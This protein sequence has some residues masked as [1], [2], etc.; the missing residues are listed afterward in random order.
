MLQS[1]V[2][3]GCHVEGLR[4]ESRS[5]VVLSA[6]RRRDGAQCPDCSHLS[7]AI[8]GHYKRRP[9][10]LPFC[11]RQVRLDLQLRRYVCI[12]ATCRRRTFAERLPMLLAHRSRRTR[13]LAQAQ[14]RVGVA[15]GGE[16]GS[17]LAH[18]L[19]MPTSGDT[20]L[21]LIRA[22]PVASSAAPAL[23]GVDD[24]ALKKRTRYGTI[25][26]DLEHR[27]PIHLLP[28]RDAETLAAWLQ[29]RPGI[30]L[31]A[32]D[33]AET[34]SVCGWLGRVPTRDRRRC[35]VRGPGRRS[36]APALQ[37]AAD[38]RA[39]GGGCACPTAKAPARGG[40]RQ[41]R[42]RSDQGVRADPLCC[43][44]RGQQP[45]SAPGQIRRGASTPSCWREAAYYQQSD[46][47]SPRHRE[48]IRPCRDLSRARA[49]HTAPSII[50]PYL[51]HLETRVSEG[52]ENG[53]QLWR[54]V[55]VLGFAGTAKLVRCWLQARRTTLHKHTPR[56]WSDVVL[57][58]ATALPPATRKLLAPSSS[59][60]SSSSQLRRDRPRRP[61]R[62]RA[63]SRIPRRRHSSGS[64]AGSSTLSVLQGSPAS[65]SPLALTP[66]MPGSPTRATAASVP[67]RPSQQV[68]SMTAL[69][70]APH[71]PCHGA[72]AR[73]KGRSP[74]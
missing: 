63:L 29:A 71:L 34:R 43:R 40:Y 11:G 45:C 26:I 31:V 30:S 52:C 33:L 24:W 13:R 46:R 50:D 69:L 36:V 59:P 51:P 3:P 16:A 55:R 19:G 61:R 21:R 9:A 62:S 73:L 64:S 6:R 68:S 22:T 47:P 35:T 58:G 27:P 12:N 65:G 74:S 49:P 72:T 7:G 48:Q 66:S 20:L 37:R 44:G 8:H 18:Q 42:R 60:G 1:F 25:I 5:L 4:R 56:R 17:R 2:V 28:D 54:E 57:P 23:I 14:A 53:T 38:G 39:M 32:R 10:D 67:S 15:L 41:P 70:S